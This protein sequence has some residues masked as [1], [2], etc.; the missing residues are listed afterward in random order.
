MNESRTRTIFI[1]LHQSQV[2]EWLA[3]V[4]FAV[5]NKTHLATE[6]SLFMMNYGRNLRMEVDIIRKKNGKSNKVCRKDKKDV[7]EGQSS[8]KKD[9]EMK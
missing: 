8:T 3:T 7:R 6:M 1:V 2:K 9:K 4:E 5:N